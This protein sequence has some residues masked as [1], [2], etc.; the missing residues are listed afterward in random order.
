MASKVV[1]PIP[2]L[3]PFRNPKQL[4]SK[5]AGHLRLWRQLYS[6]RAPPPP[7]LRPNFSRRPS[8]FSKEGGE[9]LNDGDPRN[10][11]R[12]R[13]GIYSII[14]D[15]DEDE[16]EED[17]EDRS[18][19]LLI[20]FVQNMFKK[21]S[22]K[23]RKAVRSILPVPIS[24]QLVGFSVNGVIILTFMWVL[25]AFL[26]VVC[27]L[28]SVVFVSI[29]LVRGTWIGISYLQEHRNNRTDELDD[30]HRT[31]TGTQPAT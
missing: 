26:E 9:S 11:S 27:T 7:S 16:D 6:I 19:D 29:L 13:S 17:D 20:R 12:S 5:S 22:R 24:S 30:E 15:E 25:K 23:A 31:W 10:W 3:S 4:F 2:T 8:D 21:I 14:D 1:S 18:L 28:G